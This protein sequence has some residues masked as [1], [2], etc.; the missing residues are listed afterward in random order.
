M[1]D[2]GNIVTASYIIHELAHQKFYLKGDSAFNEAF[3]TA[4]EELG[5]RR[6]LLQ[7][8]KAD[9]LKKYEEWLKQKTVFS[10]FIKDAQQEFEYL[11]SQ[12]FIAEKMR[13]EKNKKITE[14]RKRFADLVKQHPLLSRYSTWM[15]G[16]LNN[17]QFGAIALYRDLVPAFVRVFELCGADF[18]KFYKRAEEISKL[19]EEQREGM[20][21]STNE[22]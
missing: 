16:P 10:N 15:S 17:A 8:K 21:M 14:L 20:L 19:P 7:Q 11:Y 4:V 6:W 13:A 12:E 9:G 5:V 1:L 18:E 22:C 2:R 3:A